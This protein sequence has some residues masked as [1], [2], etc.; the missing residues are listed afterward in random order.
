LSE[1]AGVPAGHCFLNYLNDFGVAS[2]AH[3]GVH[4]R[5]LRENLVPVPLGQ[6]ACHYDFPELPGLLELRHLQDV[7]YGLAFGAINEA[8]GVDYHRVGFFRLGNHAVA[9]LGDQREHL[10]AVYKV[11]G[12]AK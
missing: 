8:A 11:F 1:P 2:H 9:G 3:K 7:L 4:L 12:A 6:A 10:L 5:K